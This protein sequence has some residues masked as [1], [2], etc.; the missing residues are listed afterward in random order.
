M[1]GTSPGEGRRPLRLRRILDTVAVVM[2]T[3]MKKT[4]S[5]AIDQNSLSLFMGVPWFP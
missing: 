3:I 5:M 2:M 4:I 1:T